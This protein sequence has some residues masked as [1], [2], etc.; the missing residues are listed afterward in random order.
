MTQEERQKEKELLLNVLKY[1]LPYGLQLQ[2]TDVNKFTF[3]G[4][5]LVLSK[6]WCRLNIADPVKRARVKNQTIPLNYIYIKPYLRSMSSMTE[7]ERFEV[8]Q[9]IG[10]DVEVRND[11]LSLFSPS[12]KRL[13]YAELLAV[14]KWFNEHH[15]DYRGLIEKGLAIAVTEENNPY[16][17]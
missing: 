15:F 11:F 3:N 5:L 17:E 16:K 13:S 14:F 9:I 8:E 7:T 12:I 4:E 1:G 2:I 10:Y 6:N